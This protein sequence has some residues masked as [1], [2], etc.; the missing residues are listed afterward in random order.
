M[1]HNPYSAG[2][3]LRP[4]SRTRPVLAVGAAAAVLSGA[5]AHAAGLDIGFAGVDNVFGGTSTSALPDLS[6]GVPSLDGIALSG[7]PVVPFDVST[8][9]ATTAA[10]LLPAA[11]TP[12][13]DPSAAGGGVVTTTAVDTTKI[14]LQGGKPTKVEDVDKAAV[15]LGG[16]TEQAGLGG[17]GECAGQS[18]V[19][20]TPKLGCKA[21]VVAQV[22]DPQEFPNVRVEAGGQAGASVEKGVEIGGYVN[23][24]VNVDGDLS[25]AVKQGFPLGGSPTTSVEIEG[26]PEKQQD[27]LAIGPNLLAAASTVTSGIGDSLRL[28]GNGDFERS[29]AQGTCAIDTSLSPLSQEELQ[30][31]GTHLGNAAE[32]AADLAGDVAYGAYHLVGCGSFECPPG[33]LPTTSFPEPDTGGDDTAGASPFAGTELTDT[34]GTTVTFD[35]DGRAL[36]EYEDGSTVE[37]EISQGPVPGEGPEAELTDLVDEE[38]AVE[39][40]TAVDGGFPVPRV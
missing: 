37:L 36:R 10:D 38:L 27:S 17:V 8:L 9:T 21:G 25:L 32:G 30:K 4:R 1:L 11:T 19:G 40:A 31:V 12:P 33:T 28:G 16:T 24:K 14:T 39:E 3:D 22:G 5:P 2:P 18:P 7:A 20:G 35:E 15:L 6:A 23:G 26:K 34:D 29:C 13:P